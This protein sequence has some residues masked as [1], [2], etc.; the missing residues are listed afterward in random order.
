MH[1]S[2][3]D[4]SL[5]F[6]GWSSPNGLS[7]LGVVAHWIDKDCTLRSALIGLPQLEGQHSVEKIAKVVSALIHDYGIQR[8]IGAFMLDNAANND[9]AV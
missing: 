6:D 3:S 4:V 1:T 5:S 8:K 2:L 9:T 7:L